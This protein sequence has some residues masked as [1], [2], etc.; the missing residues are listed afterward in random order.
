MICPVC[1]I[2]E[3]IAEWDDPEQYYPELSCSNERCPSIDFGIF[4]YLSRNG[5]YKKAD[6]FLNKWL[7]IAQRIEQLTK[8]QGAGSTPASRPLLIGG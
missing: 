8:Q 1:K 6:N 7:A 3:V 2:G 5:D 4:C